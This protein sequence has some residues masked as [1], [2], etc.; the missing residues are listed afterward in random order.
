MMVDGF[1]G[2]RL[3]DDVV[4]MLLKHENLLFLLLN[5]KNILWHKIGSP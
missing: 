1:Y 5:I 3:D 4:V 2:S